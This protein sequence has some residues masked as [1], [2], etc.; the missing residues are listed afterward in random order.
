VAH[1]LAAI[2]ISVA[3]SPDGGSAVAGGWDGKVRLWDLATGKDRPSF[4]GHGGPVMSVTYSPD[5][6]QV[7]TGSLDHTMRLWQ[8]VGVKQLGVFPHPTGLRPVAFSPDGKRAVSG[9]G[10]I[11]Q[12]GDWISTGTDSRVRVW[13]LQTGSDLAHFEADLPG[14]VGVAFAPDGK[15]AMATSGP[16]LRVLK[17]PE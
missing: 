12:D 8:V 1:S 4:D 11:R 16:T 9:S 3:F 2:D 5:G 7:L 10:F 6:K 17:P 15:T 13:H 14:V